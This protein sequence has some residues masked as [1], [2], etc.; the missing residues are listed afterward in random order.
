MKNKIIFV[1]ALLLVAA[2][3]LDAQRYNLGI[4][5]GLNYS[6]FLGPVEDKIQQGRSFNNGIHFGFTFAYKFNEISG[7]RTELGYTTAGTRDSIV[8]DSYY[9]F[10]IGVQNKI[11]EGKVSRNYDITNG[12]INIPLHLYI[13]PFE[14]LEIFGGPYVAFLVNPTAGGTLKF[15][16]GS[17]EL[18]Y[19]FIQSLDYNYY[20]D[21]AREGKNIGGAVTVIVDEDK[22][23]M[24]SVVGAYYQ[25]SVKNGNLFNWFDAGLSIGAQYYINRS[26]FASYR[27]DYGLLDITRKAMDVSYGEINGSSLI[28]RDD[29]DKNLSMQISLGFKF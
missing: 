22:I 19:S 11:K 23:V 9:N 8:G 13:K 20:T 7:F 10:G 14:K 21:K 17:E 1:L 28:Y 29:Y 15:D 24:P 27:L 2:I 4:R 16:D 5:A 26:F 12:Y 18:K 3:Q 6:K 25:H